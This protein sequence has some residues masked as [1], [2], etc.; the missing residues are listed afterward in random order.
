MACL[1]FPATGVCVGYLGTVSS[2]LADMAGSQRA[3][4]TELRPCSQEAVAFLDLQH[5]TVRSVRL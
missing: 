4:M 3:V 1:I 2:P 5:V